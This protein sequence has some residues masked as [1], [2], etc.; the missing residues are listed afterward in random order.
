L[1]LAAGFFE[2]FF[3]SKAAFFS[4]SSL[5]FLISSS[6]SSLYMEAMTTG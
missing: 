5:R 2:T 1:P 6:F 3:L 4:S